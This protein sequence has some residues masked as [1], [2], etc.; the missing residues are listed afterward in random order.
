MLLTLPMRVTIKSSHSV[1]QLLYWTREPADCSDRHRRVVG[2]PN[3][4]RFLS[5]GCFPLYTNSGQ[6]ADP[7]PKLAQNHVIAQTIV[8][9][10][11]VF[12]LVFAESE[13]SVGVQWLF[14][15]PHQSL[16]K[17]LQFRWL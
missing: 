16:N 1:I 3:I 9:S 7:T 15:Q 17:S 2:M 5:E 12:L 13:G 10:S 11:G 8:L 6:K 4:P 14:F